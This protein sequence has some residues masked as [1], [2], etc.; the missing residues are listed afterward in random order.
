[1]LTKQSYNVYSFAIEGCI[2]LIFFSNVFKELK[3]FPIHKVAFL[4]IRSLID[5]VYVNFQLIHR[6]HLKFIPG[7]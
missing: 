6:L 7:I 5:V 1:M 4:C 3:T 2:Y